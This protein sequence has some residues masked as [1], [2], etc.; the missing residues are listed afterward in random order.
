MALA[1]HSDAVMYSRLLDFEDATAAFVE[2]HDR[3]DLLASCEALVRTH[4]LQEAVGVDVKHKHFELPPRTLLVER[5]DVAAE[6]AWMQPM[7]EEEA[8]DGRRL[9]PAAFFF[10]EGTWVPHEFVLDS[11]EAEAALRAVLATPDFTLDL[12][13]LLEGHGAAKF[14]GF[15]LLHRGF[16]GRSTVETPG[17]APHELL[18]R[19]YTAALRAELAS[20]PSEVQQVAWAW[21]THGPIG[22]NCWICKHCQHCASHR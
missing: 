12:A 1:V 17:A 19:P 11:E 20:R 4:G 21:S 9:T 8:I 15:H 2:A 7:P 22:H 6:C 18:L 5:Q 16:L 10:A 3:D 13:A 14:F